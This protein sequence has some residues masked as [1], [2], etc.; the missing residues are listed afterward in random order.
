MSQHRHDKKIVTPR[1]VA[2]LIEDSAL[3]YNGNLCTLAQPAPKKPS[4]LLKAD[5]LAIKTRSM[6]AGAVSHKR[7]G[8]G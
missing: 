2:K 3:L 6:W 8:W 1:A 7:R 4:S 5:S